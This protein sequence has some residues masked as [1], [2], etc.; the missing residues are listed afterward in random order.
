MSNVIELPD[1]CIVRV[2]GKLYEANDFIT[3]LSKEN[4]DVAIWYCTD[5]L[6]LGMAV[7]MVTNSFI[8]CLSKCSLEEQDMINAI[9]NDTSILERSK[10]DEQD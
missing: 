1:N 10:N 9:L 5:A 3:I 4:G 7:K 8:D 2:D 6:T